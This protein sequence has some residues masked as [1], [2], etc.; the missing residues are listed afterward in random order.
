VRILGLALLA[1]AALALPAGG[2]TGRTPGVTADEILIGGT[3]PL[4]GSASAFGTVGPGANAY[5]KYV[6]AHGGVFGR[7]I[8]YIWRDDG[9]D[10]SRTIDQTRELVQQ[11]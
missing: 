2:A 7:K 10:P 6:N 11:E 3:V 4:S 9:Y 1:A 8:H 5:F